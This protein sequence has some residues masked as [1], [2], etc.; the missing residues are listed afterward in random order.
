MEFNKNSNP[1]WNWIEKDVWIRMLIVNIVDFVIVIEQW[2]EIA[3]E[4][5]FG[6]GFGIVMVIENVVDFI[7]MIEIECY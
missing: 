4:F 2:I 1:N 5:E 6:F 7:I 3:M